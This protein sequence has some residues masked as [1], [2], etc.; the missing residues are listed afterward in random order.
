MQ[1]KRTMLRRLA[2]LVL[3][4]AAA[5]LAEDFQR[6]AHCDLERELGPCK[7]KFVRYGFDAAAGEWCQ[8]VNIRRT[9]PLIKSGL[10][11]LS[12]LQ[13]MPHITYLSNI[14]RGD[15]DQSI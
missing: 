8:T 7:G 6:P 12:L 1:E 14:H 4:A 10:L 13:E 2:V 5:A 3:A 15:Q 9:R 11:N